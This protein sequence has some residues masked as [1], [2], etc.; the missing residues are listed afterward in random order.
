M[1]AEFKETPTS[2]DAREKGWVL[3]VG[4]QG[5][6][7][8]CYLYA[9]VYG[10][11]TSAF[12][13]NGYG[14]NDGSFVL[15]VQF[16]MDC[17]SFGG[18]NGGNGTEVIE[19]AVRNGWPA[20]KWVDVDGVAHKDYPPYS[21]REGN[22]RTVT[23]AKL[24]KPASWGFVSASPN[25]PA[26]TLEI[27]TALI[28]FGPLN[29]SLDAGG[30]FGN[31]T[32]TI[33]SLGGSID[34][35]IELVAFDDAKDGGAFLLKNQWST[36]WGNGGYRWATYKACQNLVDVFFVTA[37][38]LPPPPTPPVPP[39]PVPPI[40]PFPPSPD[41]DTVFSITGPRV[42][43]GT[44]TMEGV[45]VGMNAKLRELFALQGLN[46][47]QPGPTPPPPMTLEARLDALEANAATN[48]KA[49]ADI[50]AQL[51]KLNAAINGK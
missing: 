17:H 39:G 47:I 46:P 25:R 31:G 43:G 8:S 12:V 23:G 32:G 48:A 22:C 45:A 3:P 40:P 13:R 42:I 35:E 15:A 9:T 30:Q 16:G 1:L 5:S 7:G 36:S 50:A 4:N 21:A 19:W 2:F 38:L 11:M 51:A 14:K 41:G 6:C 10:T 44:M 18:C 28:N 20:E 26:T 49:L 34:H 29:V 24:W 37:A 33:T 27:K